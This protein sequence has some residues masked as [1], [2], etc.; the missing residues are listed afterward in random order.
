MCMPQPVYVYAPSLLCPKFALHL[1]ARATCCNLL[2]RSSFLSS[3]FS[4]DF[5]QQLLFALHT[6]VEVVLLLDALIDKA[7]NT[8]GVVGE[9]VHKRLRREKARRLFTLDFAFTNVDLKDLARRHGG[10]CCLAGM[11]PLAV[12][13]DVTCATFTFFALVRDKGV[14]LFIRNKYISNQ[15]VKYISNQY[16]Y[17]LQA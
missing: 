11:D 8:E 7:N 2:L 12:D 16:L 17:R 4:R 14:G 5:G 10:N 1:Q 3:F 6:H 13:E 15:Y 9:T